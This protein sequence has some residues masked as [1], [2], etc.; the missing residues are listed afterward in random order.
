MKTKAIECTNAQQTMSNIMTSL[1]GGKPFR[2]FQTSRPLI[3]QESQG[4]WQRQQQQ[5]QQQ[6]QSWGG[7]PQFNSS[8]APPSLNN[9]PVPMDLGHTRNP[10]YRG[11][12][13]GY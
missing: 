13:H 1:T 8:N 7:C 2:P 10:N 3:G 12:G 11:R 4:N 6:W 9:Q 5:Q